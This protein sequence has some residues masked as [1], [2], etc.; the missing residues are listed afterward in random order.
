MSF[1][2]AVFYLF[3]FAWFG[4]SIA[5]RAVLIKLQKSKLVG[6]VE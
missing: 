5:N 6:V 3:C 1:L 2:I 4:D